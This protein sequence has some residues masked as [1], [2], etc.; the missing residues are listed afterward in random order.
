MPSMAYVA[1]PPKALKHASRRTPK[2]SLG[3]VMCDD[4][5]L[6]AIIPKARE[7]VKQLHR[8]QKR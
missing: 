6:Y 8:G 4:R 7:D 5:M 1:M 2:L 3:G